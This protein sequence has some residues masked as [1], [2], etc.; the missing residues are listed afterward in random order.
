MFLFNPD[1]LLRSG[2]ALL[3]FP[4]SS[5][6]FLFFSFLP[7]PLFF[8]FLLSKSLLIFLSLPFLFFPLLLFII[9]LKL[10]TLYNTPLN[11][12]LPSPLT[13]FKGSPLHYRIN[14]IDNLLL[15]DN[16]YLPG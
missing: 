1:R 9:P 16:P 8:L 6:T 4:L 7:Y 11:I 15:P 12:H 14:D 2:F 13:T 5:Q 10:G 3:P